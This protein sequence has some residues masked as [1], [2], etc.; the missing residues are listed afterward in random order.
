MG[1]EKDEIEK[2]DYGRVVNEEGRQLPD[3]IRYMAVL[4]ALIGCQGVD[5]YRVIVPKAIEA[6]LSPVVVKEIVYQTVDYMG[7]GR[8]LPFLVTVNE[9]FIEL[10][11]ALPLDGQAM[12]TTKDRLEKRVQTQVEIFGDA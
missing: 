8:S 4:A 12:T 10:G 9:I 6:G 5:E 2:P 7:I 11:I 1:E 3:D